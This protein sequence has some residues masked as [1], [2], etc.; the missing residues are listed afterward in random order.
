ML[1]S[2]KERLSLVGNSR[3]T[4]DQPFVLLYMQLTYGMYLSLQLCQS[5]GL[6]SSEVVV[7]HRSSAYSASTSKS[8]W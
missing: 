7:E 3:Q 1:L 6:P 8:R 5:N 2:A 4:G